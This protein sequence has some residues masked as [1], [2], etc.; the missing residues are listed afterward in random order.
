MSITDAKANLVQTPASGKEP[1]PGK[2]F[3]FSLHRFQHL[4][5][6]IVKRSLDG[7]GVSNPITSSSSCVNSRSWLSQ[8]VLLDQL[9]DLFDFL[10]DRPDFRYTSPPIR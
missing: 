4:I 2:T 3:A 5:E 7:S 10:Q 8:Y 6:I 1:A 9:F